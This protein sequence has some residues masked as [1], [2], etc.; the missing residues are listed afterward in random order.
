MIA[1][2]NH[3]PLLVPVV[4]VLQLHAQHGRL[5]GIEPAVPANLFVVVAAIAAVIAQ[6]ANMIG[7]TG[8][9]FVLTQP[10]SP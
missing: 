2:G 8:S 3:A 1:A 5:H 7:A 10:P 9:S 4:D 6:T